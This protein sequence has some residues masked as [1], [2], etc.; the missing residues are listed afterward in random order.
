MTV[1]RRSLRNP[2]RE[3]VAV[4]VLESEPHRGDWVR[5]VSLKE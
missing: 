1:N 2:I 5:E 3:L 4:G